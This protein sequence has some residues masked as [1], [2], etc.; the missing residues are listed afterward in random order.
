MLCSYLLL[1][2]TALLLSTIAAARRGTDAG[3]GKQAVKA[4]SA[5]C[6]SRNEPTSVRRQPNLGPPVV[7]FE[8]ADCH[9]V[10][11]RHEV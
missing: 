11:G 6:Q 10:E 3:W 8:C 2:G 7:E 5:V 4:D 1:R 9:H